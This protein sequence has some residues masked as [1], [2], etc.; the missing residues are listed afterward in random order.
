[1]LTEK[2]K[3]VLKLKYGEGRKLREIAE[4]LN[5]RTPQAVYSIL[6]S[7]NR[8][9][10]ESL[11]T[12]KFYRFLFTTSHIEAEPG[13]TL[14]EVADKIYEAA[15]SLKVSV[16]RTELQRMLTYFTGGL[17]KNGVVEKRFYVGITQDGRLIIV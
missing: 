2:Q 12:V 7:A 17:T 1:M 6:K 4:K 11:E 14:E 10:R 16:G 13:E 3:A 9:V 5:L 15:G 8:N